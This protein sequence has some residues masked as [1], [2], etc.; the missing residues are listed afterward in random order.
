MGKPKRALFNAQTAGLVDRIFEARIDAIIFRESWVQVRGDNKFDGIGKEFVD[1][2]KLRASLEGIN[3]SEVDEVMQ[4]GILPEKE[5]EVKVEDTE[6]N[7][8]DDD[9]IPSKTLEVT[10]KILDDAIDQSDQKEDNPSGDYQPDGVIEEEVN[11]GP[12]SEALRAISDDAIDQSD[13]KE[14]D[15]SEDYQPDGVM[16]FTEEVDPGIII[17]EILKVISKD[18]VESVDEIIK[19]GKDR[20]SVDKEKEL[21]KEKSKPAGKKN[22][23]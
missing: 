1:T 20:E 18:V 23:K 21:V 6:V 13:Q 14:D 17:D 12:F 10:D 11:T 5:E 22:T 16:E 7:V 9:D 4:Y 8:L 2:L 15:P 19:E 3:W